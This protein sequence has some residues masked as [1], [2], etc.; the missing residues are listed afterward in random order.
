[1]SMLVY[2]LGSKGTD[3]LAI[4]EAL[5]AQGLLS[6]P[7]DGIFGAK[8]KAAVL[9][10]QKKNGL[11]RDGLVGPKTLQKLLPN[12]AFPLPPDPL[13]FAKGIDVSR[14]QGTLD[15]DAAA[16]AGIAFAYLKASEGDSIHDPYFQANWVSAAGGPVI[17]GAYH[18]F[19]TN[20]DPKEQANIFCMAVGKLAAN[21]LPPALDLETINEKTLSPAARGK[22][23][24]AWMEIVE[25][26]LGKKPVLYCGKAFMDN[27]LGGSGQ[28]SK[29]P[30]WLARYP[31][32]KKQKS[33][34]FAD[35]SK[36]VFPS[37][38]GLENLAV[39]QFTGLGN[40]PKRVGRGSGYDL[41]VFNGDFA[42]LKAFI[43]RS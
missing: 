13:G 22:A 36:T 38:L 29:Y 4:Q 17:R 32:D 41:D 25:K 43:A 19:R 1:M 12:K 39:W 18:F 9:A 20:K 42:A 33:V 30:L 24:L 5:I 2:Q 31:L 27:N 37:G 16:S 3:V 6:G 14:R 15:W 7:A 40:L 35:L 21:D 8:T 34:G 10:F 23:A 28:F 26:K 11:A